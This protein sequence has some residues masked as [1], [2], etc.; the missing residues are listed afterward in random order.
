MGGGMQDTNLEGLQAL[1]LQLGSI[2]EEMLLEAVDLL[3]GCDLAR[4]EKLGE[5]ERQL[6]EKRLTIE[7]G[8]LGMI[9]TQRALNGDLRV[10][11]AMIEIACE[12]ER[13][14]EQAKRVARANCQA[15]DYTLRKPVLSIHQLAT[16]V[17][18]ML[19]GAMVAFDNRDLAA[20]ETIFRQ[21][22]RAE[23][24]YR[25]AYQ[26]LLGVMDRRPRAAN[27]AIYLA[28]AAYN[29]RRAAERVLAINEWIVFSV[30]G[31]MEEV[32]MAPGKLMGLNSA[33]ND[34]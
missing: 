3:D 14:G 30:V 18:I 12:L 25:N 23:D 6:R 34:I 33:P 22:T 28:R 1:L 26:Q 13:I 32:P 7:M 27:Q 20:A 2:V 29:L 16:Q 9:A 31:S 10:A 21:V 11:V 8:C 4:L 17:Q 19:N 24:L 5:D 15:L